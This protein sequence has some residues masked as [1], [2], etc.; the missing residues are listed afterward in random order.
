MNKEEQCEIWHDCLACPLLECKYD[1]PR[2][3]QMYIR[4]RHDLHW[5]ALSDMLGDKG[6]AEHEG[7]VVRT[8]QQARLREERR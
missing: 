5:I 4:R 7:V 1:N 6:A 3:A 2:A 8:I